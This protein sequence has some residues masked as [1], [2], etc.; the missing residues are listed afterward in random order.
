MSTGA[1][2]TAEL[3]ALRLFEGFRQRFG[4]PP[5]VLARAPGRVNLIGE[6][7]DYNGGHVFP[8]AIDRQTLVGALPGGEGIRAWSVQ[9]DEGDVILA[10]PG[11]P[12]DKEGGWRDYLR[13]VLQ[14]A[15]EAGYPI[16][17]C[18]LM[19]DGDVPLGSGLSSS[20]ALEV[21]LLTA[22]DALWGWGTTP[23]QRALLAQKAENSFVGVACG[24]MD[25]LISA[26]GRRDHA[27]LVDCRTLEA[28]PVPLHLDALEVQI[29]V[30][31]SGVPRTLAAAGYNQRRSECEA[32]KAILQQRLGRPLG[33]LA[34]ATV[35]EFE[36]HQETLAQPIRSRLRHFFSENQR[37][38][39]ARRALEAR[40]VEGFGRLMDASHASLRDDYEVSCAELDL[41]VD[42]ARDEPGV[43][44]VR[45]TGAGFGGCAVALAR[46][47]A[48]LDRAVARYR[49]RTGCPARM[50]KLS[51]CDGAGL[52]AL[53]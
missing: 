9:Y 11:Q 25:Q 39:T 32:G 6:H 49:E 36:V 16:G 18:E 3:R 40:D 30:L 53:Q 31:D 42:L 7:T 33:T 14:V 23:T 38:L 34:D 17:P 43:L 8:A 10:H 19:I 5:S 1:T 2:T 21:S 4:L 29:A 13:G 51:A 37:V 24:V 47:T 44:G 50:W 48:D 45:L 26:L 12:L 15:R 41:L 28:D 46:T 20:A 52:V 22:F 27:L 35:E